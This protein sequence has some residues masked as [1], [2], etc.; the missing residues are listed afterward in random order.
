MGE[1]LVHQHAQH[2]ADGHQLE[3]PQRQQP[4][5]AHGA[6]GVKA[7]RLPELGQQRPGAADGPLGDGGEKVQKQRAVE[8][9]F[10]HLAVAARC[11][12]QVGDGR[13]AVKADAQR[14]GDG[15]PARQPGER[16]VVFE[17]GQN[18]QQPRNARAQRGGLV[19]AFQRA[20]AQVGQRRDRDGHR[21]HG[22]HCQPVEQPAGRQQKRAL[23]ALRQVQVD[24]GRHQQKTKKA[25]TLQAHRRASFPVGVVALYYRSI[26]INTLYMISPPG[27]RA[28]AHNTPPQ[29][30]GAQR[31]PAPRLPAARGGLARFC[32]LRGNVRF[33]LDGAGALCYSTGVVQPG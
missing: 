22:G 20:A 32:L 2:V 4:Q 24:G 16:A 30:P 31:L 19:A 3:Q 18:C 23:P 13:K 5:A 10:L 28:K 15:P 7:V 6:R 26:R 25:K 1:H 11:V 21:Q 8:R 17:K 12:D 27:A 33:C 29:K 9:V 14:H